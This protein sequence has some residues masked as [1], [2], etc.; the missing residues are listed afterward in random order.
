[1]TT[2]ATPPAAPPRAPRPSIAAERDRRRRSRRRVLRA[3]VAL[4]LVAVVATAVWLVYF[5][6]VLDTRAVVVSGTRE[7]TPEQVTAAAAV[8]LG[9][10]LARQQLDAVAQRATTLPQVSAAQVTREWP[11]TVRVSVT[12]R[13]PLLGVAQPGGFLVADKAG[14][15]FTTRTVLPPGVVEVA[16]DPSNRPLLVELGSVALALPA[17]VRSQVT[18]IAAASPDA[19]QLRTTSGLTI[20]WGDA[21]QSD[22]QGPGRRGAAR[23]GGRDVHR[24]LRPAQPRRPLTTPHRT[25]PLPSPPLSCR[26]GCRHPARDTPRRG[27]GCPHSSFRGRGLGSAPHLTSPSSA[28]SRDPGLRAIRTRVGCGSRGHLLTALYRFRGRSRLPSSTCLPRVGSLGLDPW[29]R[30]GGPG[31]RNARRA[32][33][34]R[35]RE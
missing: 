30:P 2:T 1:M 9:L 17:D 8:P 27:V 5:S 33:R 23:P 20:V 15:V 3:V 7:L 24:R 31:R 14:V 11:H 25:R 26:C 19:I 12:E 21:S 13:E 34:A 22:A 32:G 10:P 18:S 6:R 16:A 4:V 28:I 35:K 29:S